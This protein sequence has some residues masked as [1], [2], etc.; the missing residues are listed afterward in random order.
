MTT[1]KREETNGAPIRPGDVYKYICHNDQGYGYMIPVKTSSGWDFI[2][3]YQLGIPL[4]KDGET[5][6]DASIRR[7]IEL[8]H[9][10]HDGYVNRA[11]STFYHRNAHFRATA[12]PYGLRFAFNLND[13][14]ATPSSECENYDDGDVVYYVP[15]YRE[16]HYSWNSGRALGLCFVRKGAEKDRVNEF[17]SL[18]REASISIVSPYVGRASSL[19]SRI[20]EKLHELEDLGLSTQ[21]NEDDVSYLAKRIEIIGRCNNDLEKA[22][23]ERMEQLFGSGNAEDERIE[24]DEGDN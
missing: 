13:Y 15:L 9:G 18:L 16:Q 21:K 20:E 23:N 7:I 5:S 2:D 3:T 1:M 12:V 17:Q 11:T 19:L 14:D 6:D 24:S 8:G 10:E 22:R 4:S